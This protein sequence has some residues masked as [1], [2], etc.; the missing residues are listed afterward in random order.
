MANQ[1][2]FELHS[3]NGEF[4]EDE[5]EMQSRNEKL[6]HHHHQRHVPSFTKTKAMKLY[7]CYN[8]AEQRIEAKHTNSMLS[9]IH[10]GIGLT[11]TLHLSCTDD[12]FLS[13][14]SSSAVHGS[15]TEILI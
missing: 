4:T 14:F 7:I 12:T 10:T 1:M 11:L 5:A 3:D 9:I 8:P 15:T 6:H 2:I 13:F